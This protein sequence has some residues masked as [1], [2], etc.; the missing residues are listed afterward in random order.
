[1]FGTIDCNV[2]D[3]G[4]A[5][6]CPQTG[7][8]S[9][10][11]GMGD[12]SQS[13]FIATLLTDFVTTDGTGYTDYSDHRYP[14]GYGYGGHT[15]YEA[16]SEASSPPPTPD[17]IST[18]AGYTPA[19]SPSICSAVHTPP[20]YQDLCSPMTAS[21][22]HPLQSPTSSCSS[23]GG[24]GGGGSL[25]SPPITYHECRKQLIKDSLRLT[26]KSRREA[27]GLDLMDSSQD[28]S[29]NGNNT[30]SDSNSPD[31]PLTR[32]DTERRRRRRERNKVAATK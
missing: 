10:A 16:S 14:S 11:S 29:S 5:A 30:E 32:A 31:V 6:N 13:N 4:V 18:F 26:I 8:A 17:I 7:P 20:T 27:Q 3:G 19:D 9:Y 24:G 15:T 22:Y 23:M 12:E 21:S 2:G 25:A 1:M 28:M